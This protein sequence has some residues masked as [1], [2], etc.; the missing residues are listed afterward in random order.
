M[1]SR[2]DPHADRPAVAD[3]N[4]PILDRPAHLISHNPVDADSHT[5]TDPFLN[6]HR[7]SARR[8]LAGSSSHDFFVSNLRY[9]TIDPELHKP[10]APNL[11]EFDDPGSPAEVDSFL[12]RLGNA[13]WQEPGMVSRDGTNRSGRDDKIHSSTHSRI[14]PQ[15]LAP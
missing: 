13:D 15:R 8:K 2:L 12:N 5:E 11:H 1:K 7:V 10:N 14:H 4:N 6:R 9:W 3:L